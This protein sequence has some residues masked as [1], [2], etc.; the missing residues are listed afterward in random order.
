MSPKRTLLDVIVN[1]FGGLD[2][3]IFL[4][5]SVPEIEDSVDCPGFVHDEI[6]LAFEAI[7]PPNKLT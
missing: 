2:T 1:L 3:V 5:M 7:N 6:L 4:P